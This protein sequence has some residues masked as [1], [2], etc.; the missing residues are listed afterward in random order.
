M[1]IQKNYLSMVI[2]KNEWGFK[3]QNTNWYPIKLSK[4]F[5]ADRYL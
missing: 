1:K 5:T 3:K 4:Y 2:K